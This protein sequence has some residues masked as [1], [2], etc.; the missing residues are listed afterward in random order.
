MI[1]RFSLIK[2]LV[3]LIAVIAL[4][5][6]PEQDLDDDGYCAGTECKGNNDLEPG[7]CNDDEAL[8]HPGAAESCNG[9]DDDCDTLIDEDFDE[10]S[11]GYDDAVNCADGTDCNDDPD[12]GGGDVHPDADELCDGVD[13]DCDDEIDEDLEIVEYCED[14]DGDGVGS[15]VSIETCE[16]V[17]P[18]GY[19]ECTVET[20]CDD[21][22]GTSY[23][24][25][26]ELCDDVDHDCDPLADPVNGLDA[27][28]WWPDLDGD[29]YGDADGAEFIDC[30]TEAPAG[31]SGDNEDCDDTDEDINPD[32]VEACNAEDDD[33]DDSVDEDFDGDGDTV[34][35][36][37]PDGDDSTTADNDCDDAVDTTYPGAT[38]QCNGVDDDCDGI[39]DPDNDADGDGVTSCGVDGLPDTLDDDCDDGN[40]EVYPGAPEICDGL[41]NNCDEL[42]GPEEGDVDG[43]GSVTCL[44]C[45]DTD[46][47]N[48]PGNTEVCDGGDNDCG[49]SEL[50]NENDD[51]GDFYLDADCGPFVDNGV[52]GI[53]GG[54]DCDDEY[55]GTNPSIAEFCDANDNNCDGNIDEGYDIDGDG[56]TQCGLDGIYGTADDDCAGSLDYV[57]PPSG[58]NPG[59][60]EYCDNIDND[61]DGLTDAADV[62]DYLGVDFDG[63]GDAGPGCGGADCDDGDPTLESLD[64]DHDSFGTCHN[65]CDDSDPYVYPGQDEACDGVDTD[66]DG[67]VDA[68]DSPLDSDHDGD[69]FDSEGCG[70]GGTDCDDRDPHVFPDTTYTSGV[71]LECAPAVR[72]GYFSDWDFARI[73][74]PSF[75]V[76]PDDGAKYIYFRGNPL[77]PDQAIGVALL[78]GSTWVKQAAPVL[79]NTSASSGWDFRNMSSPVVV[80]LDE[81]VYSRPYIM[82]YHARAETGGLRQIGLASATDPLGPF[83][84]LDPLTGAALAAPVVGPSTESGYLDNS[85]TLHPALHYDELSDTVH[86]WY[87][88]RSTTE[89]ILRVFHAT[90]SDGGVTWT[91][92]DGDGDGPDVVFEPSET[93]HGNR[94]TQVSVLEVGTGEYEFWFTGDDTEIGA[95][96]GTETVW[97]QATV[98]P[99]LSPS[100]TCGRMDGLAVAARGIDYDGAGTYT[101]YYDALTD[102]EEFGVDA[103]ADGNVGS[104]AGNEDSVFSPNNGTL[105]AS[106]VAVGINEAPVV[107]ANTPTGTGSVDFTG[108]VTDNAADQV[109]VTLSS[110]MDGFLGTAT[111]ASLGGTPSGIVTTTWELLAATVTTGATVTISAVDEAGVERTTTVTAP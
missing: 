83:E 67:L 105:V 56:V 74:L 71:A 6:C 62:G 81:V 39:I 52:S 92:T 17:A 90:S 27:N 45:D 85:R 87:N 73:S 38:E 32:G 12:N 29:T 44:D 23:P 108:D 13:N 34:T 99:V 104:C 4:T 16:E 60:P 10:D 1:N 102:I 78:T 88:A 101:W 86:I 91:K 42:L 77:Q 64:L 47:F 82:A 9:I 72:P 36:C 66:C 3:A 106:Y 111:V 22:D 55:A 37:G 21:G 61:C 31:Y 68:A 89:S 70:I 103:N 14:G 76:D 110:S 50:P 109:I 95:A 69:G 97:S 94:T 107:A 24:G 80:K 15:D 41:D 8:I 51:D 25:A 35:T 30:A 28:S 75:F 65:D 5:G 59:A 79:E 7:D 53:V 93:W 2:S 98:D 40:D 48:F 58:G 33:C 11:D 19:V 63:D 100:G 96:N 43:D 57:Y 84:R 46:E 49:V 18:T 26:D 20:D 54:N